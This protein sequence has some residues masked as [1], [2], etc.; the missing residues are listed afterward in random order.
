MAEAVVCNNRLRKLMIE[1]GDGGC[2]VMIWAI[3]WATMLARVWGSMVGY[4]SIGAGWSEGEV[5]LRL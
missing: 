3:T 2:C 5:M 1:G 4:I